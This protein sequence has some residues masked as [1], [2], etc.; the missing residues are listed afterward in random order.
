MWA[1]WSS[2]AHG[3]MKPRTKGSRK[4]W[5]PPGVHR[6]KGQCYQ[7]L[8]GQGRQ[9]GAAQKDLG[10]RHCQNHSEAAAVGERHPSA[11]LPWCIHLVNLNQKPRVQGSR[12]E[13]VS[14]SPFPGASTGQRV[15]VK[16]NRISGTGTFV[17]YQHG[18][19]VHCGH[20]PL[21]GTV[22]LFVCL[23]VFAIS[24]A[25]PAA[26]GGSQARG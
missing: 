3:V 2:R 1:G 5:L 9:E 19:L 11:S 25:A 10:G 4:A 20:I 26:Y 14:E 8:Q 24:W 16:A 6:R 17:S 18:A 12:G 23:F 21:S 13:A 15:G 22:F 7:S